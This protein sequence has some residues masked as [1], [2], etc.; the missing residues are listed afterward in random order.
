MTKNKLD[1]DIRQKILK[2]P[3]LVLLD[4][5]IFLSLINEK[6]FSD[7]AK[8]VDIRNVFLKRL[9]AK[10]EKLKNAND[11]ILKHAYENQLSVTKI[12]KCCLSVRSSQSL[13]ELS[14]TIFDEFPVVLNITSVK[15]VLEEAIKFEGNIKKIVKVSQKKLLNF[16]Q[17]VGL[18]QSRLVIL[19]DNIEYEQ[20]ADLGLNPYEAD[21]E[22]E[23][24]LSIKIKNKVVGFIFLESSDKNTFSIDQATDYLEFLSKIISLQLEFFL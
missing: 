19:R 17:F 5:E 14:T 15:L 23:A 24:V 4:Q 18:T 21:V 12:H 16:S 8:I 11:K 13:Q 20:R 9:G 2:N 1:E 3:D 10:L 7:D 6:N 22:S